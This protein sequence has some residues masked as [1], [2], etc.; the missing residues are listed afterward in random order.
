MPISDTNFQNSFGFHPLFDLKNRIKVKNKIS[1]FNNR[2]LQLLNPLISI[3]YNTL[4]FMF[5][6]HTSLP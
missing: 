5:R 2:Q 3:C 6:N 1:K 4:I